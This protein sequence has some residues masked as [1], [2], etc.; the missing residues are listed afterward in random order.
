MRENYDIVKINYK[1]K[2]TNSGIKVSKTFKYKGK[3]YVHLEHLLKAMFGEDKVPYQVRQYTNSVE[4]LIS[5]KGEMKIFS[6]GIDYIESKEEIEKY[7][8]KDTMTFMNA[9][10]YVRDNIEDYFF[11]EEKETTMYFG[12]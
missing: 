8:H 11:E 2:G 5:T 3:E 10:S 9:I 4:I 6:N 1:F 7:A 12:K